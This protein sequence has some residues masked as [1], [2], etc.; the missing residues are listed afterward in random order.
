MT[1][2]EIILK[3]KKRENKD[4]KIWA[5]EKSLR[6]GSLETSNPAMEKIKTLDS[7]NVV[8]IMGFSSGLFC[9]VG[10]LLNGGEFLMDVSQCS[11]CA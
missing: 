10:C 5:M 8:L 4:S 11:V 9:L 2:L 7:R 1:G 6:A 3:K